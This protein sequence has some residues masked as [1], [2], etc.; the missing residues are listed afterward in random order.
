MKVTNNRAMSATVF[1]KVN[2]KMQKMRLKPFES[3]AISTLNDINAVRNN[4]VISNF[5]ASDR[6][7]YYAT[8]SAVSLHLVTTYTY[9]DGLSVSPLQYVDT[10][11]TYTQGNFAAYPVAYSSATPQATFAVRKTPV[12][13]QTKGRFEVK[14][15]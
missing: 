15:L 5:V 13:R 4:M 8:A 2:G 1:Y 12:T 11:Y 6:A 10:G 7:S 9:N 14:Y 3:L